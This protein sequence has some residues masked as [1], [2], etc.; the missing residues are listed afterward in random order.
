MSMSEWTPNLGHFRW[1]MTAKPQAG[2]AEA[3]RCG[4]VHIADIWVGPFG[5]GWEVYA[6]PEFGIEAT[7]GVEG[8]GPDRPFF[9]TDGFNE[10]R[11][12]VNDQ[13]RA[14]VPT[15]VLDDNPAP[16]YQSGPLDPKRKPT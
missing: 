9:G 15:A 1:V 10:V 7:Q 5:I 11:K 16:M 4:D 2:N 12:L 8:S 6:V 13:V 14:A 3:L